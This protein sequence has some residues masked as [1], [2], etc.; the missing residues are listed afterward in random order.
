MPTA[1]PLTVA[2]IC[3]NFMLVQVQQNIQKPELV[4]NKIVP[5]PKAV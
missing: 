4:L 3:M 2:S 5:E 1:S